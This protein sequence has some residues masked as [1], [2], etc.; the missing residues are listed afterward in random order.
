MSRR[1]HRVEDLLRAELSDLFLRKVADP[2][3]RTATVSGVSVSADLQHAVVRVSVLGEAEEREEAV[4]ALQGA[5][6]YL[7]AQLARRLRDMRRIPDLV[8]ELDRGPEHQRMITDLLE[9]LSHDHDDDQS[10]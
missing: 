2:R 8:F 3:A 7:R 5:R 9:G 10:S 4:R 1:T 6:S